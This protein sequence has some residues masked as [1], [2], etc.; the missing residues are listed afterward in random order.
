[1]SRINNY[2]EL[3]AER[4][5]LEQQVVQQKIILK[6]EFTGL[7]GK[8]EPLMNLLPV[9]N[10]FK[11][12]ETRNPLLNIISSVGIDLVGQKFLSKAGWITRFIVPLIAKGLTS[13]AIGKEKAIGEQIPTPVIQKTDQD[14]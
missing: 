9:L 2:E 14:N 11:T 4:R 8:L 3:L 12:K 13:R 5:R 6:E 10:I 7:K 1:M